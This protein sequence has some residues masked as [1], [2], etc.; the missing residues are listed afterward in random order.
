MFIDLA[1]SKFDENKKGLPH[2]DKPF[3]WFYSSIKT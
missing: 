1:F 2:R 3:N